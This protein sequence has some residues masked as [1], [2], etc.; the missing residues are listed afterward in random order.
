VG[1]AEREFRFLVKE[2]PQYSTFRPPLS[3]IPKKVCVSNVVG[4]DVD[5]V[6][7]CRTQC[8]GVVESCR[9]HI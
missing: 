7:K 5:L 1:R 8:I 2:V 4:M 3:V 6:L 9:D